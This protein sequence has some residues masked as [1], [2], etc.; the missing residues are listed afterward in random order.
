MLLAGLQYVWT[1]ELSRAQQARL[2]TA[3][4]NSMRQFEQEIQRELLNLLV[5]FLPQGRLSQAGSWGREADRYNLW[6]QTTSHPQ[7]LRRLLIHSSPRLGN[8]ALGSWTLV[9]G[10]CARASPGKGDAMS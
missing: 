2:Q 3:L 9:K 8:D 7:L 4:S 10:G 6:S 1:A 5:V